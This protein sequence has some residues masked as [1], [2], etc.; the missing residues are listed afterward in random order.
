MGAPVQVRSGSLQALVLWLQ[1]RGHV[2][3]NWSVL[4][5]GVFLE[6]ICC[7]QAPVMELWEGLTHLAEC[8]PSEEVELRLTN[9]ALICDVL[10]IQRVVG[11]DF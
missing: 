10:C 9:E 4:I 5:R 8:L 7:I 11:K 1:A 6:H 3:R 2:R